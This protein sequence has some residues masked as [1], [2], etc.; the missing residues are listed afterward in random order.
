MQSNFT[1]K[2]K[3]GKIFVVSRS[4]IRSIMGSALHVL[5]SKFSPLLEIG[6]FSLILL[7]SSDF[8]DVAWSMGGCW[9]L[10]VSVFGVERSIIDVSILIR[11]EQRINEIILRTQLWAGRL[12]VCTFWV[13]M[14]WWHLSLIV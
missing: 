11:T 4:E 13:P 6:S 8:S 3:V 14:P 9:T 5:V 1:L 12:H 2:F 10:R 7:D